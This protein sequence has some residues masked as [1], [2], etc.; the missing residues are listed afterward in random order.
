MGVT[1]S[2]LLNAL[3]RNLR[4]AEDVA[5]HIVNTYPSAW[6]QQRVTLQVSSVRRGVRYV[7]MGNYTIMMLERM[8]GMV[9]VKA[10]PKPKPEFDCHPN[11]RPPA[12]KA[13]IERIIVRAR[14]EVAGKHLE[15]MREFLRGCK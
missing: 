12:P 13:R 9:D 7:D 1:K 5:K 6:V 10:K 3:T 11:S 8:R 4:I 15:A 14:P 2:E